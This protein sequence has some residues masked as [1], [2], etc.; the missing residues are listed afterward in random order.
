MAEKKRPSVKKSKAG[1]G[2]PEEEVG[3]KKAPAAELETMMDYGVDAKQGRRDDYVKDAKIK[4]KK[5]NQASRR[6]AKLSVK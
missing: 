6:S 1:K 4:N 2:G 5:R 3:G